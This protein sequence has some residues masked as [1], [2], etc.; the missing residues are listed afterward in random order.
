MKIESKIE[1]ENYVLSIRTIVSGST[2]ID[3]SDIV[4][5]IYT[6]YRGEISSDITDIINNEISNAM[7]NDV[8]IDYNDTDTYPS[9]YKYLGN[10][11]FELY[12]D[13]AVYFNSE[14]SITKYKEILMALKKSLEP[15]KM[16]FD[17]SGKGYIDLSYADYSYRIFPR[18]LSIGIDSIKIE[19]ES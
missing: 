18:K 4:Y 10:G 19:K 3:D 14:Y 15:S 9:W 2:E 12:F 6:D 7:P 13:T 5:D 11:M 17:K 8:R 16:F 1:R